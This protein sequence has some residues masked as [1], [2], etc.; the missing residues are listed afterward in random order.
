MGTLPRSSF[1][2]NASPAC[3]V[4]PCSTTRRPRQRNR[5]PELAAPRAAF[6]FREIGPGPA[7]RGFYRASITV[8]AKKIRSRSALGGSVGFLRGE[9]FGYPKGVNSAKPCSV[10]HDGHR[11]C[12]CN[13]K[14]PQ[15]KNVVASRCHAPLKLVK[16]TPT[17]C[18]VEVEAFGLARAS[19]ARYAALRPN[20]RTWELIQGP[21]SPRRSLLLAA[22]GIKPRSGAA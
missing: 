4:K 21:S 16:G 22:R 18:A 12:N 8:G 3:P 19:A 20:I 13:V 2:R 10:L 11:D 6:A 7:L 15:K 14:S 17:A 1:V 9:C 5:S